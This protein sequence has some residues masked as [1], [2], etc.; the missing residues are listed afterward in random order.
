MSSSE[1]D[2]TLKPGMSTAEAFQAICRCCLEQLMRYQPH[3]TQTSDPEALHQTRVALRRLRAAIA[4]FKKVVADDRR[5]RIDDALRDLV[6][7]LNAARDTDQFLDKVIRPVTAEH[8]GEPGLRK[9]VD[10]FEKRRE[11]AFAHARQALDGDA[12][13]TLI[14]DAEDWLANGKW[15]ESRKSAKPIKRYA[16]K[17]LKTRRRKIAERG[18]HLERLSS[19]E[20]HKVR[21]EAKKLRYGVQFFSDLWTGGKRAA[22]RDRLL[23]ALERIQDDLGDS[24]DLAVA[25]EELAD[26]VKNP[27]RGEPP[28]RKLSYAAGLVVGLQTP[29]QDPL[30][31]AACDDFR[32]VT[33]AKPFWR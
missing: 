1:S 2:L 5:D 18:R 8:Q 23:E 22:R 17:A 4:L 9:L 31:A 24:H 6:H 26:F 19:Q 28:S 15:R 27:P 29:R 13:R 16:R 21:I 25:H 14:G 33:R 30:I 32:K 20:Q 11:S 3:F 12:F 10:Y 7:Q